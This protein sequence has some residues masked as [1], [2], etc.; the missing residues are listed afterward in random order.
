[1]EC[2]NQPG[3]NGRGAESQGV[4]AVGTDGVVRERYEEIVFI[5]ARHGAG[6]VHVFGSAAR[7]KADE[8][9]DIDV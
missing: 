9:S 5:A 8:D 3:S 6:N 7:G 2:A 1:M 4:G